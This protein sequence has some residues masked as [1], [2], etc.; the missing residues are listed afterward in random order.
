VKMSNIMAS[1]G[2][3]VFALNLYKNRKN[4]TSKCESSRLYPEAEP[5]PEAPVVPFPT[6]DMLSGLK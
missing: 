3:V 6:V 4:T 2:L 1:Y 5:V